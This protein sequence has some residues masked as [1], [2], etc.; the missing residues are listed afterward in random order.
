MSIDLPK[1]RDRMAALAAAHMEMSAIVSENRIT[2]A[3]NHNVPSSVDR[4]YEVGEEVLVFR[5]KEKKMT[6]LMVVVLVEDKI[7]TVK[8]LESA[9]V[10][11]FSTQQIKP[12]VR[13]SPSTDVDEDAVEITHEMLSRFTST[14]AK[15]KSPPFQVHLFEVI[16][17]SDPRAA[18]F[19]AAKQKEIQ[20]LIECGT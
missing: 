9:R 18:L 7:I 4:T 1:Q 8:Y 10:L 6:G 5:E 15:E 19:D 2:A 20:G 13:D 11:R 12:F 17:P 3:L 14:D 16:G